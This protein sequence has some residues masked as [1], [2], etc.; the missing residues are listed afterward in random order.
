LVDIQ[1][2]RARSSDYSDIKELV[3]QLYDDLEVKDG[4]EKELRRDKF[5]DYLKDPEIIITVAEID[6]KIHGYLTINFNKALLDIGTSAIIDELVVNATSRGRG[7]GKLLVEN[8]ITI[9]KDMGCS[10]IGVGTES[11]NTDARSFYKK[12][13]FDEIGV[14][15]EKHL[16]KRR[17]PGFNE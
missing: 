11:E 16:I 13:G 5:L 15:F 12:C 4:M 2:R 14:I 7:T 1:I 3:K 17:R 6:K 9:A 10:E 8:A